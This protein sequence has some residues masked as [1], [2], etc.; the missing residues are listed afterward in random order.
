MA[1]VTRPVTNA[2]RAVAFLLGEMEEVQINDTIRAAS[3]LKS[4]YLPQIWQH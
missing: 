4:R 1:G 2:I 3:M